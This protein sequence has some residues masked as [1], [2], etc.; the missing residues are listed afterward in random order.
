MKDASSYRKTLSKLDID[1]GYFSKYIKDQMV[2]KCI[3]DNKLVNILDIGCDTCY[4]YD[5]L[6]ARNYLNFE[7]YGIDKNLPDFSIERKENFKF[8]ATDNIFDTMDNIKDKFDCV[9]LLDVIEHMN[10]KNDGFELID[11]AIEHLESKGYLIISTPNCMNGV[12]NWPKYHKFEYSIDEIQEY[13]ESNKS[14]IYKNCLG[15]SMSN[16]MC[17]YIN[18][19]E[20]TLFFNYDFIPIEIQRVLHAI[21]NPANSRDIILI[22]KKK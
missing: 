7:Y 8:L 2:L 18:D 19:N 6:N 4:I 20:R 9:L 3:Q 14:L 22:Y 15:W 10:S 12:I 11:S 16:E 17:N 21:D 5:I 1:P 13:L